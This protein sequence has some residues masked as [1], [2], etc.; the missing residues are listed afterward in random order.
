MRKVY[1][2]V[3]MRDEM[4]P[5]EEGVV[6]TQQVPIAFSSRESGSEECR[7]WMGRCGRMLLG[8]TSVSTAND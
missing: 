1:A 6:S 5:S 8:R 4:I 2:D 7:S 3:R